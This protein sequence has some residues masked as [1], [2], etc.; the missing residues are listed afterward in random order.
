MVRMESINMDRKWPVKLDIW[1][2]VFIGSSNDDEDDNDN[3]TDDDDDSSVARVYTRV[4]KFI[5]PKIPSKLIEAGVTIP[6][7]YILN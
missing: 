4:L 7:V 5:M 6:N 3:D 2:P 1:L